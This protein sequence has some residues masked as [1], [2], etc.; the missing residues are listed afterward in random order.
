MSGGGGGR[1]I[2]QRIATSE[3]VS[4]A[5]RATLNEIADRTVVRCDLVDA[6]HVIRI[7]WK[8]LRP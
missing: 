2:I 5:D 8:Y 7:L 3:G 1:I 4:Q 6:F